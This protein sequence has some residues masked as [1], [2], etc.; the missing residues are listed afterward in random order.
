[1]KKLTA[2]TLALC[3]ATLTG[4]SSSD[5]EEELVLPQIVNQFETDVVWQESIGDGVQHYFSRLTPVV[6]DDVVYVANREGLVEALSLENGNTLWQTDVRENASFWPWETTESA[7][8][9]GGILQ[10]YGKIYIGSEH[11][12]LTALDRET[13]EIVWR[14]TM[15]GEVLAKP[16]AGDGLI[17]VNLASGKLLAVHPDTGEERWR[18]EQ[19]VPPLTLR[20]QSSP[21]VANGGVL[22]GLETGK[23]S[24]LISENGYS[25]WSAE[26]ATP[27]G[28][29]EFERLVDVDTQA[30]ISG[31]YAY[32]IAYNGNLAAVDIRSGN[33]VWKREYSSYR[34]LSMD[35][36][37]IYVVDSD[38]VVYGL[39]KTSGIERWSQ[40]A[41]RG[42]YLTGPT[43]AGKYLALG[44][45]EG[46]LHWL[47]KETGELVS[48]EDFDSSGFF[49]EPVVAGDKLI[50]YTRDGEVSAVKIPN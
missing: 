12:Y 26:I 50:L 27:K 16:A 22:L 15:P 5:D 49:I 2:A 44:D 13:G 7:K 43:V 21:T 10:A 30:L 18:F 47:D 46:N 17:F 31:P 35:S 33:V 40:P 20:G 25:A 23:L 11:G 36:Q 19:E 8:L 38:G 48:R 42:W 32:A 28:A 37:S 14:K 39:D 29:S 4:C 3:I 41:L 1:M 9:S 34:D 6:H 24:V 45:Q